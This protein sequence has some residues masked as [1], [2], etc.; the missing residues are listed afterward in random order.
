MAVVTISRGSASGGLLLA[1]RLGEKLG[2]EIVSR[3][4]IIREAARFG[5]SE[6]SLQE[7]L[8][9]PP[10]FWDRFRHERRRYLA[11]VQSA[12]CERARKDRVIYHGNAGHLLL[13]GVPHVLC[14]RLIAPMSFRIRMVMERQHL[15]REE[16]IRC[17][18][19]ADRQRREWT[20]FL[21]GKDWLDPLLY[22]L[23]INLK[24]LDVESAAEVAAAAARREV[25]QLTDASRKSMDDL[26]LA[27]RVRAALAAD[28]R[29]ASAEVSVQAD[30]GVVSLKGRLRP[31]GLVEPVIGVAS[32]VEGVR[33]VDRRQLDAPDYTV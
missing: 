15:S 10:T 5:A 24:T 20:R 22:D 19:N 18:E 32:A 26:V 30:D 12:L 2:Y 13:Q 33:K 1:E 29:T 7:A 3:E 25:Y 31:E 28:E 16:A 23:L 14:I 6:E 4:D 11:F 27:S 17:I 9:K 8:L 21:Y